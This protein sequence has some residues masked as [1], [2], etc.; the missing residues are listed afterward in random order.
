MLPESGLTAL[1]PARTPPFRGPA[2]P[3]ITA[4]ESN[5]RLVADHGEAVTVD[6]VACTAAFVVDAGQAEHDD[7][8][9]VGTRQIAHVSYLASGAPVARF[10][11]QIV[12]TADSTR[13][14]VHNVQTIDGLTIA[15]CSRLARGQIGK[16]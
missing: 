5:A 10:Q 3:P 4:S 14:T 6:G 16:L 8:G 15:D 13:W 2:M 11:S 1:P 9:G 12:R 7:P